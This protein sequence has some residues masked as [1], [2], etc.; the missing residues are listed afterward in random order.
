MKYAVNDQVILK[1][2]QQFK[3]YPGTFKP[4]NVTVIGFNVNEH[5]DTIEY[6]CYVPPYETLL[7]S[8]K[9]N[10]QHAS[11]YGIKKK[12]VGEI[13]CFITTTTVIYKHTKAPTGSTCTKC[14]EFIMYAGCDEL[15]IYV[16]RSCRE[17][18][19]R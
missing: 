8:F 9:I 7:N 19:Y 17:N 14:D 13:G 3:D 10:E 16:C 18:P 5:I 4:V 12:Y 1:V 11:Y 15:G 6:I 2:L